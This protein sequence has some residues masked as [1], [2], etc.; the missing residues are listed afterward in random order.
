MNSSL[1]WRW[2]SRNGGLGVPLP[3]PL[4]DGRA[5]Y[6]IYDSEM[7][8]T[9]SFRIYRCFKSWSRMNMEVRNI[10]S[11]NSK[12]EVLSSLWGT[13]VSPTWI[14]IHHQIP[15]LSFLA[16]S[17]STSSPPGTLPRRLF[18]NTDLTS[19][20]FSTPKNFIPG[21]FRNRITVFNC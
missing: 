15:T 12:R 3:P 9:Q 7:H 20:V 16:D 21:R 2:T 13:S 1:R 18:H 14:P 5:S 17:T 6:R 8:A 19:T 10:P 4:S 11:A